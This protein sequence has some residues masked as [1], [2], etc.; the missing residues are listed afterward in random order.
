MNMLASTREKNNNLP[1]AKPIL[2]HI[3]Q[4]IQEIS[5]YSFSQFLTPNSFTMALAPCGPQQPAIPV[6]FGRRP[7]RPL[8]PA[9][10]A[11]R[12]PR[13]DGADHGR[14]DAWGPSCTLMGHGVS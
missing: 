10:R 6:G 7:E 5:R 13:A 12:V 1:I 9:P 11:A 14:H 3:L 8:F 4:D 2:K